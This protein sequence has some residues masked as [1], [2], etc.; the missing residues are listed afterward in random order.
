MSRDIW[1]FI[2]TTGLWVMLVFVTLYDA[3]LYWQASRMPTFFLQFCVMVW[4]IFWS[5]IISLVAGFEIYGRFFSPVKITISNMYREWQKWEKENK[6]FPL[7]RVGLLMV[8]I[9]FTGLIVHLWFYG[10]MFS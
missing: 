5:A 4:A 3:M 7:S 1:G 10:G 2:R 9:A 6:L 8:W